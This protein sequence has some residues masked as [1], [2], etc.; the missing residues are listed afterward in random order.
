MGQV[1]SRVFADA[2]RDGKRFIMR[3]DERL[4]SFLE[5]ESTARSACEPSLSMLDF[6]Y[7]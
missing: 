3:A 7:D 4:T 2:H 5:L 6:H 1:C